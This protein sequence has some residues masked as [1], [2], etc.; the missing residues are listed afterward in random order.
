MMFEKPLTY[1][2]ALATGALIVIDRH[3]G[4]PYRAR[5]LIAAISAGIGHTTAADVAA[6]FSRSETLAVMI[7]TAL[8]YLIMDSLWALFSDREWLRDFIRSRLG[9]GK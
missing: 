4:K 9:G 8:G 7:M 2:I 1:W 6:Y 3:R 5:A